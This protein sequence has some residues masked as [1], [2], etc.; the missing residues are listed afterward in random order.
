MIEDACQHAWAVLLRN[1]PERVSIFAWLRVV[2]VHEAYRLSAIERRDGHLEAIALVVRWEEV[3]ADPE[4]I[5]NAL[6]AREALCVLA[7]LPAR[8]REDLA[9]FVAGYT[10]REIAELT[11]VRTFTAVISRARRRRRSVGV[12]GRRRHVA[13]GG[14]G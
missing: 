4:A 9:L 14:A 13:D 5:D 1:Q 8:P 2:A 10:C 12:L 3:A 7:D 11:D 6:E